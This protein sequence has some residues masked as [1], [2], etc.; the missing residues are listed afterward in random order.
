MWRRTYLTTAQKQKWFHLLN[1]FQPKITEALSQLAV[2]SVAYWKF[3]SLL[4]LLL[5]WIFD[6]LLVLSGC[7]LKPKYSSLAH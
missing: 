6:Q 3:Q 2:V 5:V 1:R 4:E 7:Y